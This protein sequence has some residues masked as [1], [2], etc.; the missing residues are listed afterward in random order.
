MVFAAGTTRPAESNEDPVGDAVRNLT[1]L[2]A[3]L[4]AMSSCGAHGFTFL[5]SGGAVYGPGA[6]VPTPED[7]PLWPI[8]SYG[9]VKIAAERF[10][11]MYARRLGFAADILRCSNV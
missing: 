3:T 1:P 11:A 4:E 7:A 8:S 2:T 10:V 9:I 6:P 5:S